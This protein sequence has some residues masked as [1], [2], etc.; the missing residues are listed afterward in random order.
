ML[1]GVP[2]FWGL[3]GA[4][5]NSRYQAHLQCGLGSR[6]TTEQFC[7]LPKP[8]IISKIVILKTFQSFLKTGNK[9]N[10]GWCSVVSVISGVHNKREREYPT[11]HSLAS[12]VFGMYSESNCIRKVTWLLTNPS[13]RS[14]HLPRGSN[15]VI[16]K[17]SLIDHAFQ[18]GSHVTFRIHLIH[19]CMRSILSLSIMDSWVYKRCVSF[20]VY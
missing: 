18:T 7:I 3:C 20:Y 17:L 13:T 5:A 1:S 4:C 9:Q 6:L 14:R 12:D 10:S 15:I 19:V 16:A 8:H 11:K 2:S